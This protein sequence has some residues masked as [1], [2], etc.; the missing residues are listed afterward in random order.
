VLEKQRLLALDPTLKATPARWQGAHKKTITYWYQCKWLL[1][2][3]FSAEQKNNKQQK[4]D[5]QGALAENLE[6]CRT[7]WKMTPL[8]EW[9][10]YFIHNLEGIPTNWYTDKELRRGTTTWMTLQQIFTVTFSFQ[11]ENPNIDAALK[12]IRGVIFIKEPKVEL[13]TKEKQWNKQT[14]KALLLC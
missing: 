11:H 5:G 1:C 6:K 10:H 14:V 3:S 7:L 2:I 9:P 8:E 12:Q 13:I 4:Y